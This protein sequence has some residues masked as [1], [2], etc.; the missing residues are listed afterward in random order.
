MSKYEPLRRHLADAGDQSVE[1]TFD[2]VARLVAGLPPSAYEHRAWWSNN[3][4]TSAARHGWLAAGRRVEKVDLQA[5]VVR[6]TSASRNG[7]DRFPDGELRSTRAGRGA[8]PE[9]TPTPEPVTLTREQVHSLETFLTFR[10]VSSLLR[11]RIGEV[12]L[13]VKGLTGDEALVAAGRWGMDQPVFRGARLAKEFAAQV[14][15]VLHA[16][17]ILHALP[18]VLAPEEVVK[19][20]SLGA[21]N[22]GRAHDL[23][24][25]R[26]VGVQVHQMGGR[27]RDCASGH[28]PHRSVPP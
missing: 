7:Q 5:G 13:A 24:T 14:D 11:Y 6:F 1:M 15:V 12:E 2:A 9:V 27:R 25:D 22:A 16:A 17:G 4:G 19:Y 10:G 8:V 18:H 28:A 26:Q 23:E 3:P 20:V 21:G